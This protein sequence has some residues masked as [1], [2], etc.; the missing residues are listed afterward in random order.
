MVNIH[1]CFLQRPNVDIFSAG[2]GIFKL[3]DSDS[4]LKELMAL[5]N[6]FVLN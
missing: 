6:Y 1:A 4:S 3:Y 5:V 2:T